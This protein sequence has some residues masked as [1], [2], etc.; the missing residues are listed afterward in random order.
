MILFKSHSI[1]CMLLSLY[2]L[3]ALCTSIRV[4][5]KFRFHSSR[6][7]SFQT[8][9]SADH[10]FVDIKGCDGVYFFKNL[11]CKLYRLTYY[12]ILCCRFMVSRRRALAFVSS[13][14]VDLL[15]RTIHDMV[16]LLFLFQ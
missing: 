9:D 5:K 3:W 2:V 12:H 4:E 1:L 7:L 14:S 10:I 16:K 11:M 8:A 15:M 6:T 13:R